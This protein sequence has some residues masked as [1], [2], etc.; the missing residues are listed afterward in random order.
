MLVADTAALK[1]GSSN[2]DSTYL[3]VLAQIKSLGSERDTLATTIKNDL[4]NAE[5]NNAGIPK[6]NSDL[7]HCT[8]VLRAADKLVR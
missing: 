3:N 4:Y 6:G 1:T 7:A 2:N 8:N 5:F